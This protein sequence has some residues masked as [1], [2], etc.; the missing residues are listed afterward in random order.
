M[1]DEL[2]K[3]LKVEIPR[4]FEA[5]STEKYLDELAKTHKVDCAAPRSSARLLD[6][7]VGKYIEVD[8]KDPTFLID[9]P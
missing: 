7:L 5:E 3:I 1:V 6:K 4:N 2:E 8:C 9:H